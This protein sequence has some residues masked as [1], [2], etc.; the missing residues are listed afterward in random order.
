M[1]F[2]GFEVISEGR[3]FQEEAHPGFSLTVPALR[4]GTRWESIVS[5][6]QMGR[7]HTTGTCPGTPDCN[8]LFPSVMYCNVLRVV[9]I[10]KTNMCFMVFRVYFVLTLLM[11]E[12]CSD[13]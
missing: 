7:V 13:H 3:D 12:V 6:W 1:R 2:F 9:A 4:E 11:Q 8:F 10:C 5:S